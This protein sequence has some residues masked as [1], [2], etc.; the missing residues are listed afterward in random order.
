MP[1]D[2]IENVQASCSPGSGMMTSGAV[3]ADSQ[4]PI[5]SVHLGGLRGSFVVKPQNLKPPFRR[6]P[7][8]S[9]SESD[10]RRS[11][12]TAVSARCGRYSEMTKIAPYIQDE[13]EDAG[14]KK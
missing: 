7:S 14:F 8:T 6:L 10:G 11:S 13:L 3:G 1:A 12:C 5:L 4:Q 9:S 2:L